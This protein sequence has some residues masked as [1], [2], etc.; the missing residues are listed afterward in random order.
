MNCYRREPGS[1]IACYGLQLVTDSFPRK[2]WLSSIVSDFNLHMVNP[3]TSN[4]AT[5]LSDYEVIKL[6]HTTACGG[7]AALLA[8]VMC[9]LIRTNTW[10]G[11]NRRSFVEDGQWHVTPPALVLGCPERWRGQLISIL[12]RVTEILQTLN[13]DIRLSKFLEIQNQVMVIYFLDWKNC[14]SE[15]QKTCLNC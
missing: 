11:Q 12:D 14:P 6:S 13:F 10:L 3:G 2:L 8:R 7:N 1:I 15:S 9:S 5:S 4:S